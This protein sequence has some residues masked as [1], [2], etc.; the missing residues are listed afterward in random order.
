MGSVQSRH[1]HSG[2]LLN[3][4]IASETIYVDQAKLVGERILESMVGQ[5]IQEYSF[6]RNFQA[7]T[8]NSK[9]TVTIKD[10]QVV[11]DQ[12]LLFQ[13]LCIIASNGDDPA[14]AFKY[15]L[16]SFPPGMFESPQ[17]LRGANK[18][19]LA[20]AI[21]DEVQQG[22]LESV[23]SDCHYIIDGG[24]LLQ[25]LPWQRGQS[26][27]LLC[28]MYVRYVSRKYG[29]PT[30]VFDDYTSGTSTKDITHV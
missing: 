2:A 7:V 25:R 24:T 6:K 11:I 12:Q 18:A 23:P 21:W 3:G 10:E 16:C 26:F 15:E 22:Q 17:L 27:D 1:I 29:R 4:V 14:V 19:A 20:D 13:Q 5:N 30:I 9:T 8:L 28:D